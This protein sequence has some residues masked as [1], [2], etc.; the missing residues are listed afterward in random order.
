MN[1]LNFKCIFIGIIFIKYYI[2]Q[3]KIFKV[4]VEKE[5]LKKPNG[6]FWDE[7]S[8]NLTLHLIQSKIQNTCFMKMNNFTK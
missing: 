3:I 1:G 8:T 7:G 6:V 5:R 2:I 4:K